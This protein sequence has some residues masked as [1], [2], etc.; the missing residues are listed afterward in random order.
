MFECG[1]TEYTIGPPTHDRPISPGGVSLRT[2]Q[3]E[4]VMLLK[5]ELVIACASV[6]IYLG[7]MSRP[8]LAALPTPGTEML[9]DAGQAKPSGADYRS[10]IVDCFYRHLMGSMEL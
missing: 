5:E 7:S 8:L 1:Y 10:L 3:A 6:G 9:F 2:L 4:A